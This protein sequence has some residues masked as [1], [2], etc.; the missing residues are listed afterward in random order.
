MCGIAGIVSTTPI[1]LETRLQPMVEAQRHR[2]PDDA[3][4]WSDSLCGLGHR[5]L[6]IIDLSPA[7]HQ[8]LSN[9]DG[10]LWVT[11]NGE[12]YNFQELRARLESLG[13]SFRTRTDIEVLVEAYEQ[14]GTDCPK[15]LRGMFAFGIWDQRRRRLFLARDRVGKKPLFYTEDG[16]I[17]VRLGITGVAR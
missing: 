17:A 3:G 15:H 6:S 4:L 16:S 9:R 12:I 2:G 8:P 1:V 10:T 7:G 11:F 13:H 14:W 5:R